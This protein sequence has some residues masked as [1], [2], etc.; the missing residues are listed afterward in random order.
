VKNRKQTPLT[1]YIPMEEMAKKFDI[2][3]EKL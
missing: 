2:D 3:L 1:D